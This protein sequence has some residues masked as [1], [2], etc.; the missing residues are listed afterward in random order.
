MSES[1]NINVTNTV[2]II[3]IKKRNNYGNPMIK[4]FS[5]TEYKT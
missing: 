2:L 3:I 1:I 4:L 5:I